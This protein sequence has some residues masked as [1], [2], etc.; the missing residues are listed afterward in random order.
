MIKKIIDGLKVRWYALPKWQRHA[1]GSAVLVMIFS[2]ISQLWGPIDWAFGALASMLI[3]VLKETKEKNTFASAMKDI[4][5]NMAGILFVIFA[6][7][8][9]GN[10]I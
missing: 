3:G 2:A 5:L 4:L 1:G 8:I 7:I 10:K 6:L 9:L